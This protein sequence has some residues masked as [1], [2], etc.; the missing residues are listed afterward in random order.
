[1]PAA[2]RVLMPWFGLLA[3]LAVFALLAVLA[4]LAVLAFAGVVAL[5]AC[6]WWP[7]CGGLVAQLRRCGKGAAFLE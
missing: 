4:V 5:V 7:D 2:F 1:M 6:F 3:L